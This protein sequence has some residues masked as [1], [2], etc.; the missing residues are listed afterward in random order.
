MNGRPRGRRNE[1][2]RGNERG[3]AVEPPRR[4]VG[5]RHL[6]YE[7]VL[8]Y[9]RRGVFIERVIDE[10]AEIHGIS[11]AD[12]GMAV[13]IAYGVVRRQETLGNVLKTF[14]KR[15][16]YQVQRGLWTVLEVGGYQLMFLP[17]MAA[18]IAVNETV[19]LAGTVGDEGWQSF[20]NG[21]LRR[22]AGSLGE[23]E[24][25]SADVRMIPL[26]EGKGRRCTERV[27]AD[28]AGEWTTFASQAFSFPEWLVKGWGERYGKNDA[29]ALMDWFNGVGRMVL[30][31]NLLKTTREV[32]LGAILNEGVRARNGEHPRSIVLEETTRVD[33][34]PGFRE[35][36]FSVQDESA[37]CG[38]DLLAPQPG[39]RILD[40]CAA[41]GGKTTYIGEL[42]EDRGKVVAA[43]IRPER[44]ERVDENVRRLGLNCVE[45]C[46][47][48]EDPKRL[49]FSGFEG[50]LV[51][52]PCSNT[53]VLGKRPEARWRVDPESLQ[54]L[55][56]IQRGLLK[57]ALRCV[58]PGGRVVYSTC[59]IEGAENE[60]LVESVLRTE[61]RW[62]L[63]KSQSFFPGRPGDGGYQALLREKG[64]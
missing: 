13:E 42:M 18:A 28:P 3:E 43:D 14:I 31:V 48:E 29:A 62:R 27:F 36:W 16:L 60:K 54:E 17:T 20:A 44:L 51:D 9:R 4:I 61:P 40:L 12:R 33:R 37:M 10:L 34:L 57:G 63:E 2:G 6:A 55:T 49:T 53:G 7:A 64:D 35:G 50:A 23:V 15:P 21:V 39:E 19:K 1:R 45:T 22:L 30:R 24:E 32:L 38:V 41:P 46:V 56:G 59:S 11:G 47:V 58:K 52:V 25:Y 26:K 8:A 5:G